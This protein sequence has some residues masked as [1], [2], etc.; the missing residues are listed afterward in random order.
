MKK[1]ILTQMFSYEFF[2][3]SKNTVCTEYLW[4]TASDFP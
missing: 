3:I 1:E 4:A 2:E